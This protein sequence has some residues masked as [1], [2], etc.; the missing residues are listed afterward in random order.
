VRVLF[1]ST[2]GA[3]HFN[4]LVP[5]IEGCRRGGHEVLVAGPPALADTVRRAGYPFRVGGAPPEDELARVWA[6]VPTLSY[7]DAERLVVGDMFATLNVRAMLPGMRAAVREWRP[8]V[9]V[10]EHAEFAS[11]VAAEEAGVPHLQ[12]GISLVAT[13]MKVLSIAAEAV[14]EWRTGLT[15]RI[16]QTPYLTLFPASLEDPGVAG[17]P[18]V[19]RFRDPAADAAGAPLPDWWAGDARPLV[20]VT[21]G[22]VTASEPTA[23][24]IY[25]IALEAVA[26]L[27]ARVLLTTGATGDELGLEAP[28]AHVHVARWV[29][30]ADVLAHARVVVCHGGSGTTLGALAVGVPLVVTPLFADQPQNGRRV[31]AVGAGLVVEPHD[32]G[33]IR[34]AVNP[35]ALRDAIAT[36]LADE[37]FPQ[38]ASRIAAEIRELPP[39]DEALT[40]L[41]TMP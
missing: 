6:R 23:A 14:E 2:R 17:P 29:P 21:F 24:P 26:D 8:D 3:G 19:H 11:L 10:R 34:S 31:A 41:D 22:S 4:P 36:V 15:E 28:G 35:A 20:Y 9:I 32:E 33:A 1:A 40:V 25:G 27:P 5:F 38:A 39:V 18:R 37:S 13:H 16:A 12:V 7:E 30:Q